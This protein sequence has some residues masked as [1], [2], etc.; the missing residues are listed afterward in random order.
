MN[1]NNLRRVPVNDGPDCRSLRSLRGGKFAL[2]I[3][4]LI[5]VS[6]SGTDLDKSK[7]VAGCGGLCA[8]IKKGEGFQD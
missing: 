3:G 8:E 5:R 7:P 4:A 6:A 1:V 2:Q